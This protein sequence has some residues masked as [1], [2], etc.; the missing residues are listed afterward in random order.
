MR[1]SAPARHRQ[2]TSKTPAGHRQGTGAPRASPVC[3]PCASAAADRGRTKTGAQSACSAK[4]ANSV[5]RPPD[6]ALSARRGTTRTHLVPPPV[7][8][9]ALAGQGMHGVPGSTAVKHIILHSVK[10]VWTVRGSAEVVLEPERAKLLLTTAALATPYKRARPTIGQKQGDARRCRTEQNDP[11][12]LQ[13]AAKNIKNLSRTQ[14]KDANT[15]QT[16]AT[17]TPICCKM[18]P[19]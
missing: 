17:K 10:L 5:Q 18:G 4:V 6:E 8:K 9:Q 3:L 12:S 16:V 19:N 7:P 15:L 1:Q 11:K 2:D 13:D 14:Q